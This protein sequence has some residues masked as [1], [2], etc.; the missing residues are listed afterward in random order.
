MARVSVIVPT[1]NG[2]ELLA[3]CLETLKQTSYHDFDVVVVDDGST[4]PVEPLIL[5]IFP[6]ANVIRNETNQGLTRGFNTAIDATSSEYVVL[7]NDDTEVEP[8]WLDALVRCADR[9]PHAGSV[10]SKLRLADDRGRI[11]SAGDTYSTWG[12]PGNRGVWLEDLGQ[13]DTEEEVFAACA[14]AAL[15]RRSALEAVRL[16]TG[17]IFDTRFFMYCEDV[18]L[19]WR[20]Q[21]AGHACMYAP[22]AVVY[23]HLSATGGGELASYYVAR[24]V[25][26]VMA[27]NL[28]LQLWRK[29]RFRILAHQL[30]RLAR[31]TRRTREPAARR[32]VAGTIRGAR[33]FL[34][35]R[36]RLQ[37]IDSPALHRIER[38]II[39]R[40][41]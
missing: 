6:S 8:N 28:P 10:A 4:V 24:N 40:E 39:D 9:H 12:M 29:Y 5:G 20:L 7:L 17:D 18:D 21:L 25:W 32:E 37:K 13:Y 11:H 2:V 19:A 26:Y 41:A 16:S 38:I 27:H 33:Y 1:Y 34:R 31:A 36:W 15:Y 14:G 23:H 35:H 22:D 30:G 3:R